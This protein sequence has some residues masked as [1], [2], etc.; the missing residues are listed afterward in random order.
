MKQFVV[1]GRTYSLDVIS[2]S[3]AMSFGF[4]CAEAIAPLIGGLSQLK[5]VALDDKGI[6]DK[7]LAII[8]SMASGFQAKKVEAI[9]RRAL[10][11]V[12]T[13]KNEYLRD[14][15]VFE[16]HFVNENPEGLMIVPL[17]AAWEIA[18]PFLPSWLPTTL[19]N[20]KSKAA[21]LA[22]PSTSPQSDGV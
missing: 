11:Y 10:Q 12:I 17:R 8:A 14:P 5:E 18:R 6:S 7:G 1:N 9:S 16:N 13:D 19:Q 21:S 4:E 22:S 20:M 3:E 15:K 2:A